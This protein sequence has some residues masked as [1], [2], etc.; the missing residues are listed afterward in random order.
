MIEDDD[1]DDEENE[2]RKG[3]KGRKEKRKEER[4]IS[5]DGCSM[6]VLKKNV[7]I[8]EITFTLKLDKSEGHISK[9]D[10]YNYNYVVFA[11]GRWN[12]VSRISRA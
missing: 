7:K 6:G 10:I 11:W 2:G 4:G 5:I 8:A 12:R 3:M 1:S 9:D